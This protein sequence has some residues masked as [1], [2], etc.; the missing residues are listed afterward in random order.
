MSGD[1]VT[2]IALVE[3]M[4][5]A[6]A[7]PVALLTDVIAA[8]Q[9]ASGIR[10]Q[11]GEWTVAREHA[12]T[13][14]AVSATKV[15]LK[16]VRRTPAMR[17]PILV[18]CAE[19]EWHALPA[20]MIHC[21]LRA[22]GWETTLLGASTSPM[23]LNQHLQDVGPDAVAVSCSMLGALPTT[24]RFIEAS[25]AAGVPVVV[26]GAAFG[27]DDVRAL[28]L[29]ATAWAQDAHGAVTA[30][31]GLPVVVPPAPPLPAGRAAEQVAV[32][33]AHRDLV[34]VLANGGRR[35]AR[36]TRRSRW[37]PSRTC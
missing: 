34:G 24:R 37:T 10:W 19:R 9:R 1:G 7:E 17:G 25:T 33:L 2:A 13:A 20:M 3:R 30:M 18:A 32:E 6:A 28:A 5:A 12:A 26:G 8:V 15:V 11:R 14:L 4:L 36:P 31:L 21:A 23:R 29:G 16:H 22:H 35:R 27:R